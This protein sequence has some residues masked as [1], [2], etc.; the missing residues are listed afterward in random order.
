M[1]SVQLL[2]R[3]TKDPKQGNGVAGFTLAVDRPTQEKAT[4][5]PQ[6]K[7]FGKQAETVMK[8]LHKG[9]QVVIEGS[10]ETGKYDRNGET[11]Y[12][13]DVVAHRVQFVGSSNKHAEADEKPSSNVQEQINEFEEIDEDVPF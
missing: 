5:Y 6:I 13:T 3:L 7:V 2:G 12:Y 1:N 10:I 8:Y 9:S 4:D 11:I